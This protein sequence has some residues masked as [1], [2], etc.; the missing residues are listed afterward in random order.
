MYF[1]H[2]HRHLAR[3]LCGLACVLVLLSLV[4][5][6]AFADN[7]KVNVDPTPSA[8]LYGIATEADGTIWATDRTNGEIVK[9][10]KSDT[11]GFTHYP[12]PTH[13][14]GPTYITRGPD[15]NFWFSETDAGK[16]GQITTD[17]QI[18]EYPLPSF[19]FRQ[20][21]PMGITTGPDNNLWFAE[22]GT[23]RIG[24]ITTDG[25]ITEYAIPPLL[26]LYAR[27]IAVTTGPDGNLWFTDQFS[28]RVGYITITGSFQLFSVPTSSAGVDNIAAA[29]DGTL[30]FNEE[31]SHKLANITQDGKITEY[32]S[33]SGD[34]TVDLT[35]VPS[36]MSMSSSSY[37][38]VLSA[39][40]NLGSEHFD[41]E[42][43]LY[44]V[45]N[46]KLSYE[47]DDYL[48]ISPDTVPSTLNPTDSTNKPRLALLPSGGG[49]NYKYPGAL[50]ALV[51]GLGLFQKGNAIKGRLPSS[52]HTNQASGCEITIDV[53][54][55]DD[56]P[57]TAPGP[58]VEKLP[59]VSSID[60]LK[61]DFTK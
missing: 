22:S 40:K 37:G 57:A 41:A 46:G 28:D 38:I 10:D 3:A 39:A 23:G 27:P 61:V 42:L 33:P 19:L 55:N 15:G 6:T 31:H 18:K 13:N 29:P 14:A 51:G 48:A 24:S 8:G 2:H 60:Q 52:A 36:C 32:A 16:I 34:A 5:K 12:L 9:V 47:R 58:V 11:G 43:E 7:E 56:N 4:S 26:G 54:A 35:V 50:S 25:Q 49:D 17:G 53:I 1:R 30:W 45:E 20:P 21:R 44:Q 59:P